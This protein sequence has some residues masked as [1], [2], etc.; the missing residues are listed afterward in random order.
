MTGAR[1]QQRVSPLAAERVAA[2]LDGYGYHH[3][4]DDD[5]DLT[6]TWNGHRFWFIFLGEHKEILQVRGCWA[7]RVTTENRTAA[8]LAINDWNRDMIW[9]KAYLRP[10]ADDTLA[11]YC[12]TS[13][14]LEHGVTDDQLRQ[15]V[16]CGLGTG[17]EFF[18]T[19]AT[20]LPTTEDTAGDGPSYPPQ[21]GLGPQAGN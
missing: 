20:V 5:G 7:H 21:E 17:V 11:V 8:L 10:H 19:L 16:S 18:T 3:S 14:D 1:P 15:L 2:V 6:G 12:E 9:P 4:T 13:T